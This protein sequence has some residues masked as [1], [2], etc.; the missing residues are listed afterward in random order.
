MPSTPSP[1]LKMEKTSKAHPHRHPPTKEQG[2]VSIYA[3]DP[4]ATFSL[5]HTCTYKHLSTVLLKRKKTWGRS[6]HRGRKEPRVLGPR[7]SGDLVTEAIGY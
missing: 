3:A 6:I 2:Y 7:E 4:Q 1:A 5:K